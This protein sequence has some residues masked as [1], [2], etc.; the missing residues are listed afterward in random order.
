VD[1]SGREVTFNPQSPSGVV[2]MAVDAGHGLSAVAC[3]TTAQCTAVDDSGAEVT[4]NPQSP[5]HP[6]PYAI[7]RNPLTSVACPSAGQ[8][9]A[10]DTAGVELTFAP[11]DPSRGSGLSI[12]PGNQLAA[13]A[14]RTATDCVAVDRVGVA[15]EGDPRGAG[16]WAAPRVSGSPLADV[17]CPSAVECVAVDQP[18]NAT[19]GSSGPLPAVPGSLKPPSISGATKQGHKLTESHGAWSN[20]PTSYTYQWERCSSSG[21]GCAA[22]PLATGSTYRL[23]AADAGH[24]IRIKESAYNISG[25]GAPESSAA[26]A[27]VKPLIT[28]VAERVSLSGVSKRRPKLVLILAR[29][30]TEPPLKVVSISLPTGLTLSADAPAAISVLT[31]QRTLTF[32]SRAGSHTLSISLAKPAASVRITIRAAALRAAQALVTAARSGHHRRVRV[33]LVVT[34][35]RT[36]KARLA[37]KVLAR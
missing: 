33:T 2:A 4:F 11:A 14:C 30:V 21:R 9:T 36:P 12:D 15:L 19:L 18:G 29:A 17:S 1:D 25:A 35:L 13:I 16:A 7:D 31:G 6:V 23:T 10:V 20:A 22:I 26:T 37:L 28:V 3:P 8:C 5:G 34:Q 24:R 32:A 27:V